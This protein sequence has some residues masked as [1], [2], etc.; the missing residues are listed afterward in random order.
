MELSEDVR[1]LAL[2][3][4]K[5]IRALESARKTWETMRE[6]IL[7][8]GT[9]EICC[10]NPKMEQY[11]SMFGRVEWVK[12]IPDFVVYL[13][14]YHGDEMEELLVEVPKKLTEKEEKENG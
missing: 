5:F 11:L 13:R 6:K 14:Q 3:W 7:L 8:R 4:N 1:D 9:S 12:M 10:D 2:N